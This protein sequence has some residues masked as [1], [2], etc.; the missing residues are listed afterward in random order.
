[1]SPRLLAAACAALLL[2]PAAFAQDTG[3]PIQRG[4]IMIGGNFEFSSE[5]QEDVDDRATVISVSP[6]LGY[7]IADGLMIGGSLSLNHASVGDNSFSSFGI[8]PEIAYFFGGP[9]ARMYPYVGAGVAYIV[10]S[11]DFSA[12][13]GE[14]DAGVVFMVARNV[15]LNAEAFGAFTSTDVGDESATGNTFGVRGGVVAF[16]GR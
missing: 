1:M 9:G 5:G 14:V 11:D 2:A 13:G 8:G 16:I 7:F 15:G 3:F 6:S 12:L 10:G 4:N